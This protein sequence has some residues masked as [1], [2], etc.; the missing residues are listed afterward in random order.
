MS[1]DSGNPEAPGIAWTPDP[2]FVEAANWTAFLRAVGETDYHRLA[3]RA[4]AEPEWFW[5]E[6]IEH[7]GIRFSRPFD[8]VLDLEGGIA[9]PKWCVGGRINVTTTLID[10][11]IDNGRG[12]H[13]AIR[14]EGEDGEIRQ[15]SY[16]ELARDSARAA[17]GLASLGLR[18]G[19]VVGLYM[20][21]I[22]ETVVAF[23]AVARL[24]C[25][26]LPLFSGFGAEA[27]ATR[28]RDGGAV[29]CITADGCLRRGRT[30]AMKGVVDEAAP[31]LPGLRHV[32]T[33]R[34]LG[35]GRLPQAPRTPRD[36]DWQ[37]LIDAAPA[38]L[39]PVE[40]D[41]EAPLLVVYTSGTTG[42]PKGTIHTHC[43][44]LTKTGE[45][46]LLCFDLKPSD[47][48][49]WMTDIGWLVG[50][51]QITAGLL[52][53]ATLVLA[54][55][56]PDYP[57]PGRLWRLVQDHRV[58]FLGIGPTIARMLMRNGRDQVE[59]Y[60]LSSLRVAASTGEPWDRESWSWVFE[61]VLGGSRPLMNYTG[62]TEMG[63]ILATNPLFPI[64]PASFFGPIPGTGADIL[65]D[66]GNPVEPGQVGELVM[67]SACI[68][69][70]RGLWKDPDRYIESYWSRFPGV[71]VHG[72]WA[73][74]DAGGTWYVHGRSD[75]TIK[76]AGKR[77]GP[78][79]IES[80]VLATG[81]ASD[82]AAVAIPDPRKG[83]A[84]IVAAVPAPGRD[85]R[86]IAGPIA[87]A[88]ADGLGKAFRPHRVLCVRE[89]PKT[90]NMKTMR[91]VIR[92]ALTG[93]PAGDL[94]SLVN[95]DAVEE[96]RLAAAHLSETER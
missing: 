84:V 90:R 53:G 36:V 54:E 34:R 59:G 60:D 78:A 55:G 68:G 4:E 52:A 6:L 66:S 39:P 69:T 22:P 13:P 58:T 49:L 46:F 1:Q 38:G 9:W 23:L 16:A 72:D 93:E 86:D 5:R 21:M 10:R 81:L 31:L 63:G 27:V 37:D 73:S 44:F 35:S 56:T 94:S 96:I 32:V 88:I 14:W 40:L 45:D 7:L 48:L 80:L 42:R 75:D 30:I 47:R 18:Q 24:G 33:V 2:A 67:R 61:R 26:A 12:A 29:A 20:P 8:R 57:E 62:G 64:R 71:W 76:L 51:I 82:A 92:A 28:M 50:P 15:L 87:E 79:E 3:A 95:P 43:G 65:D 83:S 77:T 19:D 70:T 41:A 89:L 25:I 91:R 11:N 85:P 17:A 74:R